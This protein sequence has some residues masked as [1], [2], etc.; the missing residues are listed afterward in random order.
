MKIKIII[1]LIF[2]VI[3][4][5]AQTFK[6]EPIKGTIKILTSNDKTWRILKADETVPANTIVSTEV[7][8]AAKIKGQELIFTLGEYSALTISS[9]KK[10]SLNDL[11]MSLALDE[12][13]NAPKQK[14]TKSDNTSVYGDKIS[15]E[16]LSAIQSNS[17]GTRRLNGAKQLAENGFAES[18]VI[19]ANDVF[20][21]YPDTKNNPSDR[22]YFAD[23]LFQ[24][25]LYDEALKQYD[26]IRKLKLTKE[27]QI[28][29]EDKIDSINKFL[30]NN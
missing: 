15:P 19:T 20:R 3:P 26:E 4:L 17:F 1:L 21:K 30:L 6:V 10:M 23:I 11:I 2:A 12:V 24:K 25:G 7:N 16:T 5:M 13:L 29:V 8:S 27:Q 9:I 22:I 14:N 28:Y 18:A